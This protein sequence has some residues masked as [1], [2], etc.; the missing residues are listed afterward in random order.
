M[1]EILMTTM[2]TY[3][4]YD[5][6]IFNFFNGEIPKKQFKTPGPVDQREVILRVIE[7]W[8][9]SSDPL[10]SADSSE[11]LFINPDMKHMTGE[12]PPVSW[13]P[14]IVHLGGWPKPHSI[15]PTT[16]RL[17]VSCALPIW[18]GSMIL[19]SPEYVTMSHLLRYATCYAARTCQEVYGTV[20]TC[21]IF[22]QVRSYIRIVYVVND[23]EGRDLKLCHWHGAL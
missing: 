13:I 20:G 14:T 9:R 1:T 6:S 15:L 21:E 10:L 3:N 19:W 18:L 4:W 5:Y 17:R 8:N 11:S 7:Y 16:D 2:P 12:S 22:M 23:N